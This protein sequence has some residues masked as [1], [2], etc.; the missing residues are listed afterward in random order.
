MK[1]LET[2]KEHVNEAEVDLNEILND[3]QD[4]AENKPETSEEAKK[5]F[6]AL[7]EYIAK[8]NGRAFYHIGFGSQ[9]ESGTVIDNFMDYSRR[10]EIILESMKQM[11]RL[12]ELR[13]MN[14]I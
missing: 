14:W 4:K 3:D 2:K 12:L 8:N 6:L 13:M 9:D 7:D 10:D 11:I 1:K 5:L